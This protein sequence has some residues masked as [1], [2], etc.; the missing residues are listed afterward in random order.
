[1]TTSLRL[2]ARPRDSAYSALSLTPNVLSRHPQNGRER[3]ARLGPVP[4]QRFKEPKLLVAQCL[5]TGE[6]GTR[7]RTALAGKGVSRVH[8]STLGI[9]CK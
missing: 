3:L 5:R 1:M 6:C 2:W 7:L 9:N 8:P 4:H